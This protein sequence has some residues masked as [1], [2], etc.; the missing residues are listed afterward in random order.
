MEGPTPVEMRVADLS[1]KI[2]KLTA[3]VEALQ[4]PRATEGKK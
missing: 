2:E 4:G 3:L 1:D